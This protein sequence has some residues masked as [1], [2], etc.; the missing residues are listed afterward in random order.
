MIP[1]LRETFSDVYVVHRSYYTADLL[2]EIEPEYL[3]AEY[4]E[5]YSSNIGKISSLVK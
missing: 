3:I 2:D 1:S 4:V 5:R